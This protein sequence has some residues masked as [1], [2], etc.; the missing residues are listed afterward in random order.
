MEQKI[1]KG[2]EGLV[3]LTLYMDKRK[4]PEAAMKSANQTQAAY[5]GDLTWSSNAAAN[6][7]HRRRHHRTHS[8]TSFSQTRNL[9]SDLRARSVGG[10]SWCGMGHYHPLASLGR[11]AFLKHL[12]ANAL[13]FSG[14]CNTSSNRYRRTSLTACLK[15]T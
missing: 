2:G 15:H 5:Y 4:G 10:T 1:C 8:C 11:T 9:I 3:L 13:P 12:G 6:S 14:P 7:H